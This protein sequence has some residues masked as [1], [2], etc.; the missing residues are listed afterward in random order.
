[1]ALMQIPLPKSSRRLLERVPL[2]DR[3][4]GL[5]LDK[6]IQPPKQ[7][8]DQKKALDLVLQTRGDSGLLTELLN[9]RR[10]RLAHVK[11]ANFSCTTAGPLTLHLC[12]ASALENAGICLHPLYGFVYMPGTGLK[13]MARAFAET[14]WLPTQADQGQAWRKIEDVFGWASNPDRRNQIRDPN[15]PAQ[16]RRTDPTDPDSPSISAA[17]GSVVFHD[18]WPVSWPKLELDIVNNHHSPYY[19]GT[20]PP[21]DWQSPV[22]VYF[23]CVPA[24]QTFEFAISPRCSGTAPKL[25]DLA[26]QWLLG[27]LTYE[28]AGAKT[29]AGYG[30]FKSADKDEQAGKLVEATDS[31]WNAA[32]DENKRAEFSC[33]L[34]LVTPAFLAGAKQEADDCDLRPATLRGLLR[35]WWRTMHAGYLD[36]D[37][38]RRLEAAIWGDTKSG[39]AVR[40]VVEGQSERDVEPFAYKQQ[41]TT[42][43]GRPKLDPDDAALRRLG[44]VPSPK[45]TTQGLYYAAYGMDEISHGSRGTRHWIHPGA[46]WNLRLLAR[47]GAFKVA[48]SENDQPLDPHMLLDQ[49]KAALWLLC[50]FGGIG[51]RCRKGFG[52]FKDVSVEGI[53]SPADVER[54][55][56]QF[57]A[58]CGL[59]DPRDARGRAESPSLADRIELPECVLPWKNPYRALDEVAQAYETTALA[60]RETGHGKHCRAKLGLGLPRQIHGPLHRPLRH[61][62]EHT[63]PEQLSVRA[64]DGNYVDRHASPLLLHFAVGEGKRLVLRVTTFPSAVLGGIDANRRFLEQFLRYFAS[65]LKERIENAEP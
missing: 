51:S 39:G 38:L 2:P 27:A 37:A 58:A 13:G 25:L 57:R 50:R 42:R 36:A 17:S 8:E 28:G 34:E 22:P 19:K 47:R 26:G 14:V 4:P 49:A 48:G 3:H 65:K 56:G 24:G 41:G 45:Y 12:R 11:A 33:T 46:H 43:A 52:S 23:L 9:R 54:L 29:A 5:Q 61:Q 21:G 30:C 7:Q 53:S 15:H 20:E 55:G 44:I 10:T 32:R 40:V 31:T 60:P 35:W 18:A 62:K 63:P 16:P 1:M 6:F 59:I 64:P